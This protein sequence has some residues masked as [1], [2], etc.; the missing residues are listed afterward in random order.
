[1][2]RLFEHR[3]APKL[4][5]TQ[6]Q[7]TDTNATSGFSSPSG[8]SMSSLLSSRSSSCTASSISSSASLALNC[9]RSYRVH[10]SRPGCDGHGAADRRVNAGIDG[11][12][13]SPSLG[14]RVVAT[15]ALGA[16]VKVPVLRRTIGTPALPSTKLDRPSIALYH[17]DGPVP[18]GTV[19]AS[20]EI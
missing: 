4:F 18:E 13:P 15:G 16:R 17:R 6:T 20:C 8:S 2:T 5:S 19:H 14:L 10:Y 3:K 9:T 11:R 7:T 1:M 12:C